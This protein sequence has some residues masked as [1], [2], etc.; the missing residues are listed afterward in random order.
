[1]RT[2][3]TL[4]LILPAKVLDALPDLPGA[5]VNLLPA[6]KLALP[7]RVE[8]PMWD[9]S[10]GLAPPKVRIYWD[11]S[12]VLE[13][14]LD[15]DFSDEDLIFS[16]SSLPL[17][18]GPHQL[19]YEVVL[20]NGSVTESPPVEVNVDIVPPDLG[21]PPARLLFAGEVIGGVTDDYLQAH[22]DT[23][24]A[25]VPAY[26]G[27]APG[28][29]ITWYWD[30]RLNTREPVGESLIT[31][32]VPPMTITF[33]G[34]I[35]RRRGD[36]SRFAHYEVTD[37]AG[38]A[39]QSG[40]V[41]LP[42]R[43]TPIPR[44]LPVPQVVGATNSGASQTLR[45]IQAVNGVEVKVPDNAVIKA[46]ETARLVFADPAQ[47]GGVTAPIDGAGELLPIGYEY[48]A[49]H[50]DR[51]L[52]IRYEVTDTEGKLHCSN[53]LT[54]TMTESKGLNF[55]TL[56]CELVNGG[57]L[58]LRQVPSTGAPVTVAPWKMMTDYQRLMIRISGVDK[59]GASLDEPIADH[60]VQANEVGVGVGN[61]GSLVI[62]RALLARLLL[63]TPFYVEGYLSFN[64]SSQWPEQPTFRDLVPTLSA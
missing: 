35:I 39:T 16:L 14:T 41:E 10:G 31:E 43:A 9:E 36:G 8:I 37:Y 22:G 5:P 23:L 18:H 7:V 47:V 19:G 30:Q 38:N 63:N 45:A 49:A 40:V 15:K 29:R 62:P 26:E 58:S 42:I 2:S 61:D 25:L 46:G 56:Q 34:D 52:L 53:P 3:N 21:A 32:L 60:L 20:G 27:Q 1:M 12:I 13:V 44:V 6:S 4:Y 55:P 59:T 64:G 50:L 48:V 54:L 51:S 17:G 11:A 28:D 24:E 57:Y 33:P